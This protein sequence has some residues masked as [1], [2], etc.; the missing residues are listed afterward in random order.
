[1]V[2]Q[3]VIGV[4]VIDDHAMF[5]QSLARLLGDADDIEV[6]G[7]ATTSDMAI[8]LAA[9]L[10][11]H[12]AIVDYLMPG[13]DG[14]AIATR[15]KA[16]NPEVMVVMLTGSTDDRILLDAIEAG[17]SGFLTKDRAADEVLA[18]VR[19]AANGEALISP[20][21]LGR[22]LPKLRRSYRRLGGD[23]SE[24]EKEILLLLA[25]GWTTPAIAEHLH[26]SP[27]TLRNQI[28]KI[29]T[30]LDA[31]SKLEAIAAAVQAGIIVYPSPA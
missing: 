17:C 18:V 30:K 31:H 19:A 11:P 23:L 6:L 27:N 29:L 14:V 28:Q 8:E 22:L 20:E 21:M 10:R 12:V 9:T 24:R 5:A 15:I 4:L 16:A 7:V 25:R 2:S 1:M 3:P 26:I 13:L